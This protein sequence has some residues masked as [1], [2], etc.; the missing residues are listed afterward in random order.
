MHS[1][2][3]VYNYDNTVANQNLDHVLSFR[4]ESIE[5]ENRLDEILHCITCFLLLRAFWQSHKFLVDV[6]E[7]HTKKVARKFEK[8]YRNQMS[9]RYF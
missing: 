4:W 1:F 8:A 9:K 6:T 5:V 7:D 2:V 3:T